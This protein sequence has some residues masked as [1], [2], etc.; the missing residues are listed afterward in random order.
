MNI[1]LKNGQKRYYYQVE[2]GRNDQGSINWI[3]K[4]GFRRKK[5]AEMAMVKVQSDLMNR[6]YFSR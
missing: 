1:H 3:K 4:R 5:N 6:R 2:N